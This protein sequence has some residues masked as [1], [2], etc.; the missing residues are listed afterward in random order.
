MR[1]TTTRWRAALACRCPPRFSP[2]LLVLPLEAGTGQAPQGLAK[3]ASERIR[4]GSSPTRMSISAAVAVPVPCAATISGAHRSVSWPRWV[5]CDLISTS[6]SSQRRAMARRLA[7]AEA[8]VVVGGPGRKAARCRTSAI[9]PATASSRSRR[10]AG[11][12][13]MMAFSASMAWVRALTAVSRAILRCRIISTSPVPALGKAVACPPSTARA[14]LSASRWSRLAMPVAQPAIGTA[15]LVD[16]MAR[17]AEKARQA[18]AVRARALDAEGADGSQRLGPGLKRTVTVKADPDR[19]L[20]DPGAEPSDGYG[21]VGVLVGVDADNDGVRVG[22]AHAAGSPIGC[23][24]GDPAG[25]QDCDGM[26]GLR[27]L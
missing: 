20:P 8:V 10:A 18:G 7:L 22:L 6:R 12:L 1:T 14:A 15:R 21:G 25:G 5:S 9:L 17:R 2:C 27:L 4:S 19:Q 3:A 16:G 13:T 26:D 23:G 11:A 24:S